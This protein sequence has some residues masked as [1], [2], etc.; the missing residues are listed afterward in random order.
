[1]AKKQ[2]VCVALMVMFLLPFFL[3]SSNSAYAQDSKRD[4]AGVCVHGFSVS[5]AEIANNSGVGW[6]RI[7]A[8]DNSLEAF[9]RIKTQNQKILAVLYN[10]L[11]HSLPTIN[12]TLQEWQDKVQYYASTFPFVDAWEI[13]NEPVSTQ[14]PLWGLNVSEPENLNTLADLYFSMVQ[15]ASQII[16]QYNP[17]ATIV[18]FGG[19]TLYSGQDPNLEISKNF[20]TLLAAKNI[21]DYGDAIS[22]HGYPWGANQP[23]VWGNYSESITFYKNLFHAKGDLQYWL[24]ETG[25]KAEVEGELGQ[26][27]YMTDAL[28]FFQGTVDRFFW[29]SLVDSAIAYGRFG[30][31][32]DVARPAF[33]VLQEFLAEPR[34][35]PSPSPNLETPRTKDYIIAI[36]AVAVTASTTAIAT[37]LALRRR[38]QSS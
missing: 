26:A 20:A 35:S 15:T 18:L 19:L 33:G 10:Q 16:H 2:A 7:E 36:V 6:V 13:W 29:Y 38:H 4:W 22:F 12:F 31:V 27:Q 28:D 25:Q 17:Q 32:G 9:Q 34:T 37:A 23:T 5:V 3:S 8:S 1:M 21:T 24:T 30:L 14:Y 11:F